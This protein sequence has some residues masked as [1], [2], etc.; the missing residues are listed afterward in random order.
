M[1]D[2]ASCALA[3]M[4]EA[5][6]ATGVLHL[7]NGQQVVLG[8]Y[9]LTFD[10]FEC[11]ITFDDTSRREHAEICPDDDVLCSPISV[12]PAGPPSMASSPL[13]ASTTATSSRWARQPRLSSAPVE[14][15]DRPQRR[16]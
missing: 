15:L 7:S 6:G 14:R 9:R 3:P 1:S 11:T 16:Q 4:K 5:D 12:P 13:V 2:L 10:G 8:E